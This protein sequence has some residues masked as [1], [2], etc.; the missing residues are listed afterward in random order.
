[1]LIQVLP[2]IQ[3]NSEL[4]AFNVI[5]LFAGQQHPDSLEGKVLPCARIWL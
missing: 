4:M 5:K 1:M 3:T 2:D